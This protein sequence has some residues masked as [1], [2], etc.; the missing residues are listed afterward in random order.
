MQFLYRVT[1]YIPIF[2][3]LY[4]LMGSII[5]WRQLLITVTETILSLFGAEI[6]M[7]LGG[8]G[9]GDGVEKKEKCTQKQ[10]NVLSSRNGTLVQCEMHRCRVQKIKAVFISVTF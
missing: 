7:M 1:F 3:L 4:F 6:I 10:E 9:A 8:E 2:F 5:W